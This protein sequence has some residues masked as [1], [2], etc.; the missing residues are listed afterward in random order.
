MSDIKAL[1]NLST[2]ENSNSEAVK[3]GVHYK[4]WHHKDGGV[5][6]RIF[7]FEN[8]ELCKRTGLIELE[9]F[10]VA[11][12]KDGAR[13]HNTSVTFN[14]VYDSA[15]NIIIGIPK[16]TNKDGNLEF[17][18]IHLR[19]HQIF[20]LANPKDAMTWAVV[21]N[22][23]YVEGSPFAERKLTVYRV[24]DKEVE[25]E[26][27]I[28]KRY[29][30]RK[31]ETIAEALVG[32]QL[33]ETAISL[34]VNL[35]GMSENVI[36][37]TVC[38][39]AESDPKRFM[40]VWDSP[41]KLELTIFKKALNCGVIIQDLRDGYVYNTLPLG[42]TEPQ[43]IEYLKQNPL[44]RNV[45]D[46]LC[47]QKESDTV[48]SMN[49]KTTSPIQ[50]EKDAALAKLQAELEAMKETL[51]KVSGAKIE[52]ITEEVTGNLNSSDKEHAELLLEAKRLKIPGAHLVKDKEALRQKIKDKTSQIEN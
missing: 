13:R 42:V 27:Y 44:T 37:M 23:Y 49:V 47:K 33:T 9:A 51:K 32:S 38:K 18:T 30:K 52:A 50:D 16:G 26:T 31:A 1:F 4:L 35:E 8:A 14:K 25:A 12:T 24:F 43:A 45:I 34:G 39:I 29:I 17:E 6:L 7:N 41:N 19:D 3:E 20:D 10:K 15:N 40:E 22:S 11:K 36:L 28:N 46:M 48:K 21:K 5:P 2:G